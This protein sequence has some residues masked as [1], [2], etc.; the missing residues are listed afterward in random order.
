MKM[1]VVPKVRGFV[2]TTAHPEGCARHVLKQIQHTTSQPA[3]PSGPKKVLVIGAS[4]GYG[5]ASRIVSAFGAKAQ[6]MGV[7]LERAAHGTRTAS[8]GWYN[9]AAFEAEAHAIGLYAKSIN[10]DAFSEAVKRKTIE[11]IQH[12]WGGGIDL[13]V[14]SVA[15]PRRTD[16]KTGNCFHSVLKPI[17]NP[18]TNKTIDVL[19]GTLSTV[20]LQPATPEEIA[21]TIAVMGGEDWML[22]ME[23]LMEANLLAKGVQTVAYSYLGPELTEPI[24][25]KGT[26]GQ[27]KKHLEASCMLLQQ[28]LEP[29]SGKAFVSINKAVVTQA[30]AAIP[31]V[32]LYISLLYKV[33][34]DQKLH[35][36][37]M[38]QIYRLYAGW[39]YPQTSPLPLDKGGLIR[40]D[41]W[42][43]RPEVQ[44]VVTELWD[45]V[46]N[47]NLTK[48]TDLI[49][50][51]EAFYH[52]FGFEIEGVDYKQES[53]IEIPIP[54]L[55]KKSISPRVFPG[56]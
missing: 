45:Q 40:I 32:P 44:H 21:E 48:L 17:G 56:S 37:C 51:R 26:I 25:T 22:W 23:A 49:G 3:L 33:M 20:C 46:N 16:P 50:Y 5:L 38:E 29:I 18:Y 13:V 55:T 1:H 24:Y 15:S 27:A 54:S 9:T 28:K 34:K 36:G 7:F 19:S 2:C 12:D 39:L 10:G 8:A 6:T 42:E 14:Y 53:E 31:I 30:S 4:T 41:N 52:L 11:Q 47:E 35:E 43:M